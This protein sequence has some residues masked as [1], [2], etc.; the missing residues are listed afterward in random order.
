MPSVFVESHFHLTGNTNEKE[1]ELSTFTQTISPANCLR[2]TNEVPRFMRL[3]ES[4]LHHDAIVDGKKISMIIGLYDLSDLTE[5]IL[6]S[7]V[8]LQINSITLKT[9][10]STI[11]HT[12]R[13]E[14][15]NLPKDNCA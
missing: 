9:I 2:T 7:S 4:L 15:A 11:T 3:F 5:T 8:S 10:F 12:S 13:C 1:N 14:Y 6:S